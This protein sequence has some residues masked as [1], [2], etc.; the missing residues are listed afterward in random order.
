M[1]IA[2]DARRNDSRVGEQRCSARWACSLTK[3]PSTLDFDLRSLPTR[4][5]PA[6]TTYSQLRQ[7]ANSQQLHRKSATGSKYR[8]QTRINRT[9]RAIRREICLMLRRAQVVADYV[10]TTLTYAKPP[11]RPQTPLVRRGPGCR[12]SLTRPHFPKGKTSGARESMQPCK[13]GRKLECKQ[14]HYGPLRFL[15]ANPQWA[16]THTHTHTRVATTG[17]EHAAVS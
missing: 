7:A 6:Q 5:A 9:R 1:G 15:D 10:S 3:R 17:A 12:A 2:A 8:K 11:L 14:T 13:T 16:R 4:L